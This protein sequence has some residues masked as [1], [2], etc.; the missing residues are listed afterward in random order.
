MYA[1]NKIYIYYPNLTK[2]PI[3]PAWLIFRKTNVWTYLNDL[4][5][6]LESKMPT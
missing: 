5:K 4:F 6:K 2:L 3:S 1:R